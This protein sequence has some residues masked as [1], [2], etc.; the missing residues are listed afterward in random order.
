MLQISKHRQAVYF[1]KATC[2]R[3]EQWNAIYSKGLNE[4]LNSEFHLECEKAYK[5]S[6]LEVSE[7]MEIAIAKAN[8]Q[9]IDHLGKLIL[10]VYLDAKVLKLSFFLTFAMCCW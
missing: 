10:Q 4:H 7:T 2:D 8:K 3:I 1:E 6:T 9:Q 5:I